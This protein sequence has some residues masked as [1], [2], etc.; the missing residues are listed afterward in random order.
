MFYTSKNL[1]IKVNDKEIQA[2]DAQ[3]AYEAQIAPY[4]EVDQRYAD[5]VTPTAPIQGTLTFSYILTG[6][7][8]MKDLIYEDSSVSF[9]FGGIRQ[10]G[11]LKNLNVRFA[12]HSQIVSTATLN[13][14]KSPTGAFNPIFNETDLDKNILHIDD[15]IINNFNNQFLTGD[16]LNGSFSYDV[17]LTPEIHVGDI[18]E[19][20]CVFGLKQTTMTVN[21]NNFNPEIKI[22]GEKVA[23]AL[24]LKSF[25]DNVIT[26]SYTC[27]GFLTKKSFQSRTDEVLTSEVTIR[28]FNLLPEV[29]IQ[30]ISPT[31]GTAGDIIELVGKN[32]NIVT[33]V[34]FDD[35][36]AEFK[37]VNSSKINATVPRLQ[38]GFD[39]RI[40][41]TSL[42]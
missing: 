15:V 5:T 25:T 8:P 10:T 29:L 14:F 17:D 34:F 11:Y 9:D 12:P 27:T 28:Q 40:S 32:F 21:F 13:F 19:Q 22:S 33:N 24:S 35:Y 23:L 16:I 38:K 1:L 6:K 36:Q 41:T 18:S 20:R 26:E 4:I 42:G 3:L 39:V 30:S 7:D 31:T 37:V 2:L